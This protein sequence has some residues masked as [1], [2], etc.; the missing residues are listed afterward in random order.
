MSVSLRS[1]VLDGLDRSKLV[2]PSSGTTVDTLAALD[3]GVRRFHPGASTGVVAAML[4]NDLPSVELVLGS[5]AAGATLV[6]IPL[7]GRAEAPEHYAAFVRNALDTTGAGSV[8]ARDDIADL[9]GS[10]GIATV[11]HASL[12][13]DR[14]L[15]APTG[16]FELVQFSSGSTAR[17][18]AIRLSSATLTANITA[19]L[20]R[21]QPRSGD[22]TISWL[23]L[24]HDMGLIGMLLSSLAATSS[25]WTDGGEIVLLEPERFLR[26]P[27]I[28]LDALHHW[29]G[30]FTAAPDFG[31][32]LATTRPTTA[33]LDL[34]PL[35]HAI[36][37]GEVIRSATINAFEDRFAGSKLSPQA[38]APAYGMAELGLAATMTRPSERWIST[39]HGASDVVS[40]GTALDG[41]EIR[42]S[43]D[44]GQII[45][46]APALGNLA[47][48]PDTAAAVEGSLITNDTGFLSPDGHLFVTGRLDDI[49]VVHGRNIPALEL[50]ATIGTIPGV[51]TGRVTA[52]TVPTGEWIIVAEPD[53]AVPTTDIGPLVR[54]IRQA[55]VAAS[56]VAP[57]TVA[58]IRPGTLPMTSS[59]KPQR[60]EARTRWTTEAFEILR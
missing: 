4:T 11:G 46:D 42:I 56:G 35:R 1:L 60:N 48:K 22:V 19:I 5:I 3:A 31:Y 28:W 18:K 33:A 45:I 26:Q 38:V 55:A 30:T 12:A 27:G 58:L 17:P 51:R 29:R 8:I 10:V 43:A 57:D 53:P 24:S 9:M 39:S 25:G 34:S 37:G 40:S 23:P 47:N 59:G 49:L 50:E 54:G 13:S 2:F 15:A 7:P 21:V 36:M 41:Y 20:N 6:S 14:P 32:R 16:D 44:T 52:F